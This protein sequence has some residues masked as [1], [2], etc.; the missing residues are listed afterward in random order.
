MSEIDHKALS[1][2]FRAELLG[3]LQPVG[4]LQE[5]TAERICLN[6]W[7]LLRGSDS[8]KRPRRF[9]VTWS[10]GKGHV[11][12]RWEGELRDAS[13]ED[14]DPAEVAR[15]DASLARQ[16][17]RDLEQLS[18]MQGRQVGGPGQERSPRSKSK[19]PR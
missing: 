18:L 3:E 17:R 8:E 12:E 1:D 16:L 15:Y 6:S 7:R 5:L 14:M 19:P 11:Y 13:I 9:C 4:A 2:A 10:D